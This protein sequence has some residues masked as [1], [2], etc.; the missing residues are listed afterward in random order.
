LPY[1]YEVSCKLEIHYKSDK[2][3]AIVSEKPLR[4]VLFF[5]K[6]EYHKQFRLDLKKS[7]SQNEGRNVSRG[8]K[9]MKC[10]CYPSYSMPPHSQVFCVDLDIL[11]RHPMNKGERVPLL[12][13]KCIEYI[14][15]EGPTTEGIFRV[16]G[17]KSKKDELKRMWNRGIIV[18]FTESYSVQN[19]SDLIKEFIRSLPRPLCPDMDFIPIRDILRDSPPEQSKKLTR[20]LNQL[21]VYNRNLIVE[22]CVFL[23]NLA[24]HNSVTKMTEENL[25][26]VWSPNLFSSTF[27]LEDQRNITL[28][29]IQNLDVNS[30]LK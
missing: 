24:K 14:A 7:D 19:A 30:L 27:T 13:K 16:C 2:G 3:S 26:L 11:M 28:S 20:V 25:C 12:V 9:N 21:T 18:N 22:L 17:S 6:S 23:R 8:Y 1:S 15:L 29:I 5:K 4:E 10:F